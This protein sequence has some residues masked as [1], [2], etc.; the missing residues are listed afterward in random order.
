MSPA[1]GLEN[2]QAHAIQ[3]PDRATPHSNDGFAFSGSGS[4][5]L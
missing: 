2:R 5:H 1:E 4:I 3:D